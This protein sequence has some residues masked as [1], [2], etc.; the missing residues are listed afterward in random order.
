MARIDGNISDL[1]FNTDL[2]AARI[3][4]GDGQFV[5]FD[6]AV[7]REEATQ[8]LACLDRLGVPIPAVNDLIDDFHRRL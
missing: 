5:G 1:F 4:N 2:G 3:N 7:L 6:D 8:F